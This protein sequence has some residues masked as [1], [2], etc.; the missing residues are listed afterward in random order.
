MSKYEFNDIL[1]IVLRV[2][3][4]ISIVLL[5]TGV[6][7]IFVMHGADGYTI[8]QIASYGSGTGTSGFSIN[9]SSLPLTGILNG[10]VH[11]NGLYFISLGLWVLI[12]TPI[13]IVLIA[14]AEFAYLRNR[15]YVILSVIVLFDLFFA[16]IVVPIY[17]HV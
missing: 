1:S 14:L 10:V 11:L 13:S 15:L 6:T 16:M 2:G 12:F 8:D 7:L 5:A 3:V 17:F 9:S 4:V